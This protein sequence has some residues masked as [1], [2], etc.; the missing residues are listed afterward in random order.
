VQKDFPKS[1]LESLNENS[2]G[3]FILFNFN[4][5]GDPQVMTKFDNQLNAMALQQYVNYWAE[6]MNSLNIECT[7]QNIAEIGKKKRKKKD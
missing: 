4:A 2:F 1:L 3:G 6:A 7:I 5:E